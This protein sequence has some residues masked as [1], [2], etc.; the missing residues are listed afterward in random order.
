LKIQRK[1]ARKSALGPNPEKFPVKFPVL[2]EF[3]G[4]GRGG[5]PPARPLGRR[6]QQSLTFKSSD[7]GRIFGF[8]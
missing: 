7:P 3:E 1:L 8:R 4:R 5:P 2:R 6:I